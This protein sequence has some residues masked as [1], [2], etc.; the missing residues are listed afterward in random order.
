MKRIVKE[1]KN[2]FVCS[3]FSQKDYTFALALK[4]A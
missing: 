1:Y 2:N 3:L 4:K